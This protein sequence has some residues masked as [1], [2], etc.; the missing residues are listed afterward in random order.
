MRPRTVFFS[1]A[2][3]PLL[4]VPGR[5]GDL[6]P[7][8]GF[9]TPP[10]REAFSV[11]AGDPERWALATRDAGAYLAEQG[12]EV[13]RDLGVD[14]L[15]LTRRGDWLRFSRFAEALDF[16]CPSDRM[17]WQECR[18]IM[19]VCESEE[20]C[21]PASKPTDPCT[22]VKVEKNCAFVCEES[23]WDERFTM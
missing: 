3:L 14:F 7:L 9:L 8:D 23:V 18:K 1:L 22:L 12:I 6:F 21:I 16:Y 17:W 5:A 19:R 10:V 2:A 11:A 13:P 20:V 4:A 15:D